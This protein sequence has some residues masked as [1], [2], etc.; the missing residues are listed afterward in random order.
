MLIPLAALA[1]IWLALILVLLLTGRRV[2]ARE[3]AA[4]VPNML[5]LFRG[6]I[7]DPR[8]PI[9]SKVLLVAAALWLASPIDLIPEFIPIV[10]PLDDAIVAVLVL[11]YVMRRTGREVVR[12]HWRGDA[13]TFDLILRLAGIPDP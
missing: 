11:R 9:R 6:L 13:R 1:A 2:A 3:V 8:V 5:L 4:F 10:G 12:P 7:A